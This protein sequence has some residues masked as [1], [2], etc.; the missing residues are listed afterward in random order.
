MLEAMVTLDDAGSLHT[1]RNSLTPFNLLTSAIVIVVAAG[2]IF[3]PWNSIT[4]TK[5][6]RPSVSRLAWTV[7]ASLLA[8]LFLN[9]MT[10]REFLYIDF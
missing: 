10:A 9:S 2:S 6:F 5:E 1:L 8:L 3:L 7:A 4:L